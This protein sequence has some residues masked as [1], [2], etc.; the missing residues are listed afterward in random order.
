VDR[1]NLDLK[2][3]IA[4]VFDAEYLVSKHARK[5]ERENSKLSH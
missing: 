1:K 5:T 4:R 2:E 3:K